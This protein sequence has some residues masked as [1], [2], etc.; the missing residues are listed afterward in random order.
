MSSLL[1]GQAGEMGGWGWGRRQRDAGPS[2][3]SKV[4]RLQGPGRR[5]WAADRRSSSRAGRLWVLHLLS[6]DF[7]AVRFGVFLPPPSA[8][9]N[10]QEQ[11]RRERK[12]REKHEPALRR[13]EAVPWSW[14]AF[15]P[16]RPAQ[17]RVGV[18]VGTSQ[19]IPALHHLC[20]DDRWP[21]PELPGH[22]SEQR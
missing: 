6:V 20:S 11:R 18:L 1:Q 4:R 2:S 21:S 19:S 12:T 5:V 15:P 10:H 7:W 13:N 14:S 16:E 9:T 8:D 22:P 3:K 17:R